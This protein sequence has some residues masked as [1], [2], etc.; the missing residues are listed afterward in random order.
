LGGARV[1]RARGG[2][3]G[4]RPRGR[5][6]Q[7]PGQRGTRALPRTRAGGPMSIGS[8]AALIAGKDLKIETRA[9]VISQ[10]ILPFGLIV[11]L[12]FAFALDPDR[13][14]P[15]RGAHRLIV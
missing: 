10:Q 4:G 14:V 7:R 9:R 5:A 6:G 2:S 8:E 12:L 3:A 1:A 11:L 15:R 13:G